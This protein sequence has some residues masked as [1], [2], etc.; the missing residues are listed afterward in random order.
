M[1]EDLCQKRKAKTNYSRHLKQCD[2]LARL[3]PNPLIL[4]QIYAVGATEEINIM[5][6]IRIT[7]L[8]GGRGTRQWV[9]FTGPCVSQ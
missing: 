8:H 9:Y 1:M 2:G 6:V 3:T 4:R 5:V 7:F